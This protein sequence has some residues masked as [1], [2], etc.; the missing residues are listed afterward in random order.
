MCS[1]LCYM[2]AFEWDWDWAGSSFNFHVFYSLAFERKQTN[3]KEKGNNPKYFI[4]KLRIKNPQHVVFP[5]EVT[6][7]LGKQTLRRK[8]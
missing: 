2:V 5:V 3:R 8:K 6:N 7:T 4:V 1:D